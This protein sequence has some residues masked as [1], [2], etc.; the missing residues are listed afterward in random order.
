M[1]PATLRVTYRRKLCKYEINNFVKDHNHELNEI[2]FKHY[3]IKRGPRALKSMIKREI[4][5]DND[6]II[7]RVDD[8]IKSEKMK[9]LLQHDVDIMSIKECFREFG[10]TALSKDIHN[11]KQKL[12]KAHKEDNDVREFLIELR[13]DQVKDTGMIVEQ[14]TMADNYIGCIFFQFSWQRAFL[15]R[16]P[17][18]LL[19]DSTYNLNNRKMPLYVAIIVD[20]NNNSIPVAFGLVSFESEVNVGFFFIV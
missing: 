14:L 12:C 20:G 5:N 8:N 18:T 11:A 7:D 1:C 16:Y 13:K 10:I 2:L 19:I 9:I 4:I 15:D 17:E 3:S 6:K